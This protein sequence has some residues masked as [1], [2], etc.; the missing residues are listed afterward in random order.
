MMRMSASCSLRL[1]RV[2]TVLTRLSVNAVAKPMPLQEWM[3]VPLICVAAM[4]VDAVT[5]TDA[6]S[7]RACRMNSLST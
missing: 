6:P 2:R 3:V 1:R 7:A 5:A 4:P